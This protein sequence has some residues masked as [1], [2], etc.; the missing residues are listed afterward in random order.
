VS[1]IA[2][3]VFDAFGHIVLALVA[4]GPSATLD[5]KAN[6]VPVLALKEAASA[7]SKRLGATSY[8]EA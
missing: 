3:P 2:T 7:L 6:G 5:L 1:A 4:I 8:K